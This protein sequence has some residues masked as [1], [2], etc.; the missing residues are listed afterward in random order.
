MWQDV[1]L[2]WCS[3]VQ[4]GAGLIQTYQQWDR[5][6][7]FDYPPNSHAVCVV[8]AAVKSEEG[9]VRRARGRYSGNVV[10]KRTLCHRRRIW[11]TPKVW[12]RLTGALKVRVEVKCRHRL[13]I[14]RFYPVFTQLLLKEL[15]L[16]LILGILLTELC[17]KNHSRKRLWDSTWWDFYSCYCTSVL[18]SSFSLIFQ[19]LTDP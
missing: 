13:F 11:S 9:A 12:E 10:I 1:K 8:P 5:D 4:R 15:R 3:D 19:N 16:F 14:V 6:W 17:N 7:P 2:G 18:F